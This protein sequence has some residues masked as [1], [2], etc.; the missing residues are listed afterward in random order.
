MVQLGT[1]AVST[2]AIF[3]CA[4][5]PDLQSA[6]RLYL[7][8]DAG[9]RR[10]NWAVIAVAGPVDRNTVTMTNHSWR[11]D[12]AEIAAEFAL[13]EARLV[14]DFAALASATPLLDAA[15]LIPIGAGEGRAV[16]SIT[17]TAVVGAG[18]GL[19]VGGLVSGPNGITPLTTEGGHASFA[20]VDDLE[21]EIN[22]ALLTRFERVS[23]ERLLCGEGL[24]NIHWALSQI[25]GAR[26]EKLAPREVTA[27]AAD[28]SDPL[29]V[30]TMQ[31][32]SR[33]MGAFAGDVVLMFG[34][35]GGAFVAGGLVPATLDVF[36]RAAFR[37]RFE[38]KGR[39]RSYMEATPAWIV[40]HPFAALSGAAAM[41]QA[42]IAPPRAIAKTSGAAAE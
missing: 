26:A 36:D 21:R 37:A 2:P 13:R 20:P 4:D 3:R 17:T 6:L 16:G 7:E 11:I 29:S 22:K 39:F 19:G 40:T 32:F 15:H 1:L 23:N 28:K 10:P 38:A 33:V 12:G 25:Q 27:R 41:A 18:T 31:V 8:R 42:L 34:A 35:R 9:R 24:V 14:N 5:Y 30:Q